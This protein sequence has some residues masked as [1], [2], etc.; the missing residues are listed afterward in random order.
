MHAVKLS[1]S[2]ILKWS[3]TLVK[4]WFY[5]HKVLTTCDVVIFIFWLYV[6]ICYILHMLLHYAMFCIMDTLPW[7]WPCFR[8]SW[9]ETILWLKSIFC[10]FFCEGTK[11]VIFPA[12]II[13]LGNFSIFFPFWVWFCVCN[14]GLL[15]FYLFCCLFVFSQLC[16]FCL[17]F[18]SFICGEFWYWCSFFWKFQ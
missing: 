7:Q 5:S 13:K 2:A 10:T 11:S 4:L 9:N 18:P 14:P 17:F 12:Q 3:G 8:E 6:V 15:L 16:F 1:L